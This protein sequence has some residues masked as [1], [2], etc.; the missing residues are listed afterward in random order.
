MLPDLKAFFE[1]QSRELAAKAN[2][3]RQLIG[4]THWYTDGAFKEAILLEAIR[5]RL[6]AGMD[7]H[8]GFVLSADLSGSSKEQDCIVLDRHA[9]APIFE[10]VDF[11][12]VNPHG[13]SALVSVKTKLK[14]EEFVDATVGLA[15]ALQVIAKE[16]LAGNPF[17]AVFF[18]DEDA[19]VKDDTLIGWAKDLAQNVGWPARRT[20][21]LDGDI[22]LGPLLV[23]TLH[24]RCFRIDADADH[25]L[26]I[27][28]YSLPDISS[29]VFL[30]LLEKACFEHRKTTA[31]AAWNVLD[32]AS[33]AT[34][35]ATA[36]L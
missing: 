19:R 9:S 2:R 16:P 4:D 21:A 13:V 20:D 23:F 35:T 18:F 26:R 36:D 3:V 5:Q 6:P 27:R 29:A 22:A 24:N 10:A 15:S 17:I 33:V 34:L 32:D 28:L 30:H 31:V 12:M 1:S 11:R 8:R 25:K 7:A 14:K